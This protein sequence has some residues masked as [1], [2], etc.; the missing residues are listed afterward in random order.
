MRAVDLVDVFKPR[1]QVHGVSHHRVAHRQ[2]RADIAD[3]DIAGGDANAH[4]D[5]RHVALD[6]K[7]FRQALPKAGEQS[8][9]P[10]TRFAG[11]AGLLVRVREGRTPEGHDR[12]AHIFVD[13]SAAPADRLR[14]GRQIAVNHTDQRS[15][16]YALAQRRK[17]LHIGEAHRHHPALA[18]AAK[19]FRPLDQVLYDTR[20][21]VFAES[22]THPRLGAELPH[23][24]IEGSGE[25]ANLVARGDGKFGVEGTS[26]HG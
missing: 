9:L 12:V 23:H 25:V 5:V 1:G 4:V 24:R 3:D 2:I 20:I 16:R 13:D 19:Q 10:K 7:H 22:L 14:H 17:T 6:S 21:E 26:L 11:E 18:F 8:D 15:G